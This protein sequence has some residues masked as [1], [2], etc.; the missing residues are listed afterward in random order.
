MKMKRAET[1]R[2]FG[3]VQSAIKELDP[4]ALCECM[5]SYRRGRPECGDIDIII[6]KPHT[7]LS[8]LRTLLL[9]TVIKLFQADFL[10]CALSGPDPR[11]FKN[12]LALLLTEFSDISKWYGASALEDIKIWR[13]IDFLIVPESELGASLLYFTGNQLFNRSMRLLAQKKGYSLNQHG[14]FKN[15]VR[16]NRLKTTGG[17]LVEGRSERKIFKALGLPYREPSERNV[18]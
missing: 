2:H 15:V 9:R 10:K 4:E 17:T 16:V 6:T 8:D 5:G 12:D 18:I 1:E 14:L 13:R 7:S 3:V 11:E